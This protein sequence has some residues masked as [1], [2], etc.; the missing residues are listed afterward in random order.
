[1]M[2]DRE[3]LIHCNGHHMMTAIEP[4]TDALARIAA[5]FGQPTSFRRP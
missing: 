4:L 5:L 3:R 1:M 2:L